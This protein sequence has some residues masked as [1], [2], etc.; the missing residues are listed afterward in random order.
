M[1]FRN[2]Y[3]GSTENPPKDRFSISVKKDEYLQE[4]QKS[5]RYTISLAFQ[6]NKFQR[7]GNLQKRRYNLLNADTI[8]THNINKITSADYLKNLLID[9]KSNDQNA[10]YAGLV[11]LRVTSEQGYL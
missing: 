1:D 11:S 3:Q 5:K 4:I 9:I 2:Q 7:I 10:C 8:Q 6:K